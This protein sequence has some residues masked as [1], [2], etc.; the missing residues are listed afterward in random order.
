M[1]A[2]ERISTYQAG[3]SVPSDQ[4]LQ[5]DLLWKEP[6]R[7]NG[8]SGGRIG[9]RSGQPIGPDTVVIVSGLPRSGT[10]MMMQMLEAGGVMA[11]TDGERAADSDN[12]RGY[13]EFEP[14]KKPDGDKSWVEDA[15]GKSVKMIAHLLSGLPAGP[16]YRIVFMERCL[17]DVV[18]SQ[19]A[20]LERLQKQGARIPDRRLAATFR[21]QVEDVRR[22]LMQHPDR[23]TVLGIDYDLSVAMPAVAAAQLNMFFGGTLDEV[24]MAAAVNPALRRQGGGTV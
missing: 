13:M 14:A 7:I 10:S 24:A 17:A 16:D 19:R 12:P 11:L 4:D 1:A 5:L 22:Y 6:I 8:V 9:H 15:R 20:M 3:G 2:M 23:F 18:Q 21:R